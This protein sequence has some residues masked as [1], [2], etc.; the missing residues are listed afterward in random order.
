SSPRGP[1]P[2]RPSRT[3]GRSCSSTTPARRSSGSTGA[4]AGSAFTSSGRSSPTPTPTARSGRSSR[5]PSR[6]SSSRDPAR[7]GG[8]AV[9]P[10]LLTLETNT[11]LRADTVLAHVGLRQ[12]L[13]W[14]HPPGRGAKAGPA[15]FVRAGPQQ[16]TL[17]LGFDADRPG[18]PPSDVR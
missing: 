18:A 6:T 13:D 17:T 1:A 2:A 15:G 3:T 10:T 5:S 16:L 8:G 12:G 4:T 9:R 11:E 7:P 14:R